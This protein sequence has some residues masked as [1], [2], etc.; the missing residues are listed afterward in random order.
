[1]FKRLRTKQRK[2]PLPPK[3]WLFH[4]S[5]TKVHI[6]YADLISGLDVSVS[7]PSPL[8]FGYIVNTETRQSLSQKKWTKDEG[9][10]NCKTRITD[11]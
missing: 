1:M 10:T 8:E 5:F 6:S 3:S 4:A 9:Q 2:V 11:T 7:L